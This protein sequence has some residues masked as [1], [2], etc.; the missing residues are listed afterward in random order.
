MKRLKWLLVMF[1]LMVFAHYGLGLFSGSRLVKAS[2]STDPFDCRFESPVK[3]VLPF[4]LRLPE[5][6][7][8]LIEYFGSNVIEIYVE[9][10]SM[11]VVA[12]QR[13]VSD[14][15]KDQLV[16]FWIVRLSSMVRHNENATISGR[17]PVSVFDGIENYGGADGFIRFVGC[18]GRSVYA[19][20]VL[21]VISVRRLFDNK[22]R[23]IYNYSNIYM[24]VKRMDRFALGFLEKLTIK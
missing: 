22:F 7:C 15:A 1:S 3:N 18:D 11:R 20:N 10:P 8:R 12:P 24:D 9:Y 6:E 2:P 16:I 13:R 5:S 14:T 23:V 19:S 21:D 4:E 17:T